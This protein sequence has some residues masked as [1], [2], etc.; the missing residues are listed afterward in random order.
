[1]VKNAPMTYQEQ[2]DHAFSLY[3]ADKLGE[4]ASLAHILYQQNPQNGDVLHLLAMVAGRNARLDLA[5]KLLEMAI[6]L[7][8]N[9]PSFHLHLGEFYERQDALP[10][11]E[12]RYHRAIQLKPD[13]VHAHV[14]LG[15][16]L[17]KQEDQDGAMAAYLSATARDGQADAALYNLGILHQEKGQHTEALQVFERAIAA[18]PYNAQVHTARAFSLLMLERFEEGWQAYGWRWKL[19]DNTPR[20]CAQPLWDGTDP[21]GKRLYIYTEQGFGDALMFA[22]YLPMVRA[23]GATLLLECKPELWQLF[24]SS[25]LADRV[26][27]RADGDASEPPFDFDYHRP[28]LDLPAFYTVSE[29]TI[30]QRVPYLTASPDLV[31]R[32]RERLQGLPGLRVA[33][34]WSGNPKTSVNRQRACTLSLFEPLLA[35]PHISFISVQKGLPAQQLHAARHTITDMDP[36]LTDFSETAALLTH[37]D[38]LIS[39]DTAVVHLAGA[40]GRPVWVLLHHASE[41]RWL[42]ERTDSPWYPTARLFRQTT[43]GDWPELMARVATALRRY[44][45]V[46]GVS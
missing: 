28:L 38:L 24:R 33:I 29:P 41:W 21:Q 19:P 44:V 25:G 46:G 43:S 1:M 15:N 22:R 11:A 30:P 45:P 7:K 39:T 17:F 31:A 5:I 6:T 3:N 40:L 10:Q 27:A 8:P 14:N 36:L 16:V 4:A 12:A 37:V 18:H 26:V 34:A 23:R 35:I 9:S 32:W 13:F 2:L 20:Q 42:R